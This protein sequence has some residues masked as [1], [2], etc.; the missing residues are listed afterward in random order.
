MSTGYA[1]LY[2]LGITPWE[3]Y[4]KAAAA[5]IEALLDREEAE[6]SH[7]LGRASMTGRALRQANRR[8]SAPWS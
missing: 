6:R 3:R 1:L 2:R 8:P 7:P 4:G 5:S